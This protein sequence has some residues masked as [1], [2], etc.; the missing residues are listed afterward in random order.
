MPARLLWR[1]RERISRFRPVEVDE[2]VALRAMFSEQNNFALMCER[3]SLLKPA[4]LVPAMAIGLLR[5]WFDDGIISQ[6]DGVE[7]RRSGR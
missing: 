6:L 7:E 3:L 4:E 2:L 1:D 5:Q